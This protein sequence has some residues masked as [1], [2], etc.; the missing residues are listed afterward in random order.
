MKIFENLKHK[1]KKE[2]KIN[3][4]NAKNKR[5]HLFLIPLINSI[6]KAMKKYVIA[7]DESGSIN[8]SILGNNANEKIFTINLNSSF[9]V[10]SS[11]K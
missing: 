2:N 8:V 7:L 6:I 10:F 4:K 9:E 11:L 3:D 1:M 5:N